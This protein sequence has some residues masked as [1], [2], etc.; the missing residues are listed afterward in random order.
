MLEIKDCNLK[1]VSTPV[2]KMADALTELLRDGAR[3]LIKQAWEE[4][5]TSLRPLILYVHAQ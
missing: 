2:Q 4:L 1:E 3:N 5:L